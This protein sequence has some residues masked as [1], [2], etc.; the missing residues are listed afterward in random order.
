MHSRTLTL[1]YVGDGERNFLIVLV[2][3]AWQATATG[4]Y[5]LPSWK[6]LALRLIGH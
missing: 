4:L 3:L 6:S 2:G 5:F 1:A